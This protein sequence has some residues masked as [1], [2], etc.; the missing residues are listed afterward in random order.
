MRKY[1]ILLVTMLTTFTAS[2]F[3]L[4]KEQKA[5]QITLTKMNYGSKIDT[6]DGSVNFNHQ[7]ILHWFDI[8]SS[9]NE[10][11]LLQLS[12]KGF[13]IKGEKPI[14]YDWAVKAI[15][16]VNS[17]H[18]TVKMF[19]TKDTSRIVICQQ[20]ILKSCAD[21]SPKQISTYL[22]ILDNARN[23]FNKSYEK[24]RSNNKKEEEKKAAEERKRQEEDSIVVIQQEPQSDIYISGLEL[25][26]VGF[27]DNEISAY[28][29]PLY[30]KDMQFLKACVKAE[31]INSGKYNI[32]VRILNSKGKPILPDAKA[33]Y[34]ISSD[35]TFAKAKKT[36]DIEFDKFGSRTTKVWTKGEYTFE[37]YDG[38]ILIMNEKFEIK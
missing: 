7:G 28:G 35:V 10:N 20:M 8:K 6:K 31:S 21:L 13:K 2:A 23:I 15:N 26:N 3:D 9:T 38:D 12:M 27:A 25:C 30:E 5:L 34:T 36:Y 1:L 32:N 18:P 14:K 24:I 22:E 19:C 11:I 17:S 16:D 37:V 4:S 29:K 33:K